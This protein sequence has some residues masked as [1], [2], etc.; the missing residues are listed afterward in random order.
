MRRSARARASLISPLGLPGIFGTEGPRTGCLPVQA[1]PCMYHGVFR[2]L[3]VT[4][5]T[6]HHRYSYSHSACYGPKGQ[7]ITAPYLSTSDLLPVAFF[8]ENQPHQQAEITSY[9]TTRG[10]KSLHS[11]S[12]LS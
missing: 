2:R 12:S 1:C 7:V 11:T 10:Y 3:T 8:A 5:S 4:D 6:P 9:F